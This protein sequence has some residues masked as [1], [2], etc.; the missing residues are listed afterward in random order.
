MQAPL[1]VL[2]VSNHWGLAK[3]LPFFCI[4]MDRQLN[5]LKDIGV[6]IDTFDIGTS[7]SPFK[8]F[9]KCLEL[10]R[11]VRQLNPD[12][13]HSL[14]GTI[15]GFLA[16]CS[17]QSTV[18]SFCGNDLLPGASVSPLR[19]YFGFL[20]SN[21]SALGARGMICK[22]EELRHALWWRRSQ[23]QIIPNG[24]DLKVFSPG[25]QDEAR[26]QLK[27]DL[28]CPIVILN[29]G[30]DPERK[31][32]DVAEMAMQ[33]VRFRIPEAELHIISGVEPSRM[34]LYY[35]AADVLLCASKAEGS[36][37]VIKEALACNLPVVSCPVGDV[38]E[39]LKGVHPSVIVPRDPQLMGEAIANMLLTKRRSNGREQ[40]LAL[41][42]HV[43]ARRVLDVYRSALGA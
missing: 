32:L 1:R 34:P 29:A 5:S 17:G 28:H 24:V 3:D 23:A 33:H 38:A 40:M 22:S 30:G 37:N 20:L 2:A 12:I 9:R 11:K 21:L 39:R 6:R 27:W 8:L 13:V 43:V 35:R 19:M 25:A 31:G 4:F 10:R 36:P 7:H 14:Y 16:V 18:V 42:L 41:D 26:K 15:S